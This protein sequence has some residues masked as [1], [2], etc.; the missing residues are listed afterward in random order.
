MMKLYEEIEY[1]IKIKKLFDAIEKLPNKSKLVLKK[2]CFE[3]YS[4]QQVSDELNISM[5]TVKTHMYRS[6]K[7]LKEYLSDDEMLYALVILFIINSAS[8]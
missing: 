7:L 1:S 3:N 6:Y 5:S 2:I 4:Y 8:V